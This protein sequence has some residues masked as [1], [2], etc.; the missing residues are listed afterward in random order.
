MAT[1]TIPAAQLNRAYVQSKVIETNL[2]H[3]RVVLLGANAGIGDGLE[4][5][6]NGFGQYVHLLGEACA[7]A[8]ARARS[9]GASATGEATD[10]CR[11]QYRAPTTC[12]FGHS[13]PFGGPISTRSRRPSMPQSDRG[14]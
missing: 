2:E 13:P 7:L 12:W 1:T 5:I 8:D 14:R 11:N 3:L 6:A 4:P 9:S 10:A